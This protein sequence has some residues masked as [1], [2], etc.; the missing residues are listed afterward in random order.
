MKS[1]NFRQLAT[2]V[3]FNHNLISIENLEY[4][5]DELHLTASGKANLALHTVELEITG[6]VPRVSNSFIGGPMGEISK[7][8][9]VQRVIDSLTL[10]KLESLPSL[11][12][13]GEVASAK[14]RQFTFKILAPYDQPKLVSHSIEKSFRWTEDRPLTT[15]V[16]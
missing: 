7:E 4:D 11:P 13:L 5:G 14:P 16:P 10:H 9:T 12:I 6:K 3:N 1:G 2:S 8:F 15:V